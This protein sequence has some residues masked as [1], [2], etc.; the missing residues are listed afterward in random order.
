MRERSYESF[1]PAPV[2]EAWELLAT[3]ERRPEWDFAIDTIEPGGKNQWIGRVKT[4]GVRTPPRGR[5]RTF[6]LTRREEPH[7]LEWGHRLPL[8]RRHRPS[9]LLIRLD[10]QPGGTRLHLTMG[11]PRTVFPLP[12][13][14]F[15]LELTAYANGISRALCP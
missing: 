12:G 7:L 14:F 2:G 4:E 1:V 11:R 15:T 6:T 8:V 5:V 13:F 9:R 10:G 3:P